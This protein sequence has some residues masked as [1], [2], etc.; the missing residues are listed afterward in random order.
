MLHIETK[1]IKSGFYSV[2]WDKFIKVNLDY[3]EPKFTEFASFTWTKLGFAWLVAGFH[4]LALLYL[5]LQGSN[6]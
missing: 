3:D 2:C 4:H 5:C 1:F 6:S